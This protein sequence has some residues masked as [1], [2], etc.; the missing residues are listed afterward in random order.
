MFSLN[1]LFSKIFK[2]RI[3]SKKNFSPVVTDTLLA[4][5]ELNTL[6]EN[7]VKIEE[8]YLALASLYRMQGDIE[9][10]VQIHAQLLSRV[11][12]SNDLRARVYFELGKDYKRAGFIDRALNSF[13]QAKE[14]GGIEYQYTYELAEIYALSENY[15]MAVITAK[16]LGNSRMQAFYLLEEA[17]KNSTETA[18][19]LQKKL[20]KIIA[21]EPDMPKAW[22]YKIEYTLQ[23]GSLKENTILLKK[24]LDKIQPSM[25]FVLLEYILGLEIIKNTTFSKEEMQE[26]VLMIIHI[27]LEHDEDAVIYYYTALFYSSIELFD[28]AKEMLVK[29]LQIQNNFWAAHC[30]LFALTMSLSKTYMNIVSPQLHFF[31]ETGKNIKRF[32][33]SS[34]GL[35]VNTP[36]YQCPRC[37]N[38]KTVHF[39]TKLDE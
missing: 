14:I 32:F 37:K 11:T 15:E 8:V 20:N 19:S 39:R 28:K 31:M 26:R 16:K 3:R 10:A 6:I 2:N 9:K 30:E 22:L 24:A 13:L 4:I 7:D 35:K 23:Y 18:V 29:S 33:C 21:I 27:L 25:H 1:T 34:C 17:C 36:F 12:M 38:W 5:D